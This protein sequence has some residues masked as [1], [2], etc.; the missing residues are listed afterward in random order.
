MIRKL[1]TASLLIIFFACSG[2]DAS[3]ERNIFRYNEAAGVTSL[4]PAF[5]KNL[6]NI[7]VCNQLFNGLVQLDE[8]L[9]VKPAIARS[10]NISDDGLVYTFRLR[11]NVIFHKDTLFGDNKTR[12]VVADD[13]VYSF[14]RIIDPKMA[15]PGAWVFQN[16]A[17]NEGIPEIYALNDSVLQI[18][19]SKPFPPFL[20]ILS[21]KYCSV[22]PHEVVEHYGKDFRQN[23]VGTGPFYFKYWKEGV[24][25][26]FRK[27]TGYFEKDPEGTQLPYIDGVAITFLMDKQAAFLEFVKGNIDF[28][29]GLDP[30]YKDEILTRD[31]ML[32]PKYKDRFY[33][34]TE[35]YL[36]TEYLGILMNPESVDDSSPLRIKEVRQAINYGFDR[37]KMI[38]YLRNNIGSPGNAGIIPEGMPSFDSSKTRAYQYNPEKAKKLLSEAGFPNGEG[39]AP[40][41]LTTSSEYLDLCKFIQH[42]LSELGIDLQIDVSP[43]AT[44]KELKAQAKLTF[45]RASWI[46]D[47]PEAENY[48]SLFYSKNFCP[49]GPNYTHF[50]NDLYDKWFEASQQEVEDSLRYLLYQKMDS[51]MMQE[52]PVVILY[53]DQ[54][55]RFVSNN[56]SGLG[57][58]P[59]NQLDLR[60]LKFS[61][62]SSIF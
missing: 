30:G 55:L 62:A 39:M 9:N 54:V 5:A 23:P 2:P 51:L 19:L 12:E 16:I 7:W 4:D 22:V 59:I 17:Y 8:Q 29:S 52:S 6:A 37:K 27:H 25:L 47:Y 31:G 56:I 28:L 15:S 38:R 13:F 40:L 48:L 53:Y 24:K 61:K 34:L 60:K 35:P 44:L 41:T 50:S 14:N 57:S 36:N 26:I 33:L 18:R 1:I 49:A 20:G 45:F 43:P 3:E 46:A 42:E 58:N 10:W 11:G 21:M 32:N